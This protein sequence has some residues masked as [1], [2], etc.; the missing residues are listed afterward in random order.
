[1]KQVVYYKKARELRRSAPMNASGDNSKT[2]AQRSLFWRVLV[3]IFVVALLAGGALGIYFWQLGNEARQIY[4]LGSSL[5][6]FFGNYASALKHRNVDAV[7]ALY[8][9]KYASDREGLWKEKLVWEDEKIPQVKDRVRIY[10]WEEVDPHR[11]SQSNLREQIEAQLARMD[12]VTFA[13]FKIEAIEEQKGLERAKLKTLLWLRGQQ[14]DGETVET[15]AYLRLWLTKENGWKIQREEL[16]RGTTVRGGGTGFV[17]VTKKAGIDFK[18]VHNPMLRDEEE[19]KPKRYE[20]MKYAHGGVSVADYDNSGWYSIFFCDGERPRLYRNRGDGTF[21]DVTRKAGLPEVLPGVSV[22]LFADFNNSGNVDL[23]LGRSTGENKLYRNNGDGTFTDVTSTANIGG[24]WVSV[25]AAADYDNDGRIDLYLGRYLD[26]RKNVPTTLFYTRNGEGNTLLHNDG[27]YRF[28]DVTAKAGVRDGGL[29]LGLCWGDYD[30]DGNVDVYVA[31]DYGR[32]A[33]FKNNGDGTFTDVSKKSGALDIGYAMSANF[34]D[35]NNSGHL[36]LYIAK[37]H[38]GQ[39]WFGNEATLKNY[40]VTSIKQGTVTE[41]QA[42]LKEILGIVGDK[43]QTLG[44]RVIRGNTLF[45]NNGDGTFRDAPEES[46]VSPH[47][48]FWGAAIFDYGNCGNQDIF[49]ADGWITG[50]QPDDL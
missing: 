32:G 24:Y 35:L 38:S 25:A 20:I 37:V 7:L 48:W 5:N 16:L 36:D 27:N 4:E 33:L 50:K 39:R 14:E 17:D 28:T 10:V 30:G 43:W 2:K 47:G 45:L 46:G 26:P 9:D 44:D 13:K 49:V 18:A 3:G 1:V 12:Y 34:A 31:N 40:F 41:D 22:A 29:T 6:S 23:F 19:W 8:H 15:K 42:L 11:F 21:E